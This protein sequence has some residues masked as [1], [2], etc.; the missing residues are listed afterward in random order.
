AVMSQ[1]RTAA[2]RRAL[3][4]AALLMTACGDA[5]EESGAEAKTYDTRG[6]VRQLPS[7]EGPGQELILAHEEIPTFE[8]IDGEIVGM[9]PMAMGF[10]VAAQELLEG[11]EVGDKVSFTL[12]VDWDGS[13]PLE[14][15]EMREIPRATQ[16]GFEKTQAADGS[17]DPSEME[18]SGEE[19]SGMDHSGM[20]HT[21]KQSSGQAES[22]SEGE[23]EQTSTEQDPEA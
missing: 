15:T 2:A 13:P 12:K 3:A 5:P 8:S 19:N 1:P 20:G 6:V 21:G 23:A 10:P 22:A 4:L 17:S 7:T 11:L 16:L 18:H 9:K 14:I